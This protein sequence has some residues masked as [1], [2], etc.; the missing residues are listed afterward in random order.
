MIFTAQC[1]LAI[2]IEYK[3]YTKKINK[4]WKDF[5]F[6]V[7]WRQIEPIY[8]SISFSLLFAIHKTSQYRLQNTTKTKTNKLKT[9]IIH[10]KKNN[11]EIFKDLYSMENLRFLRFIFSNLLFTMSKSD[12][13]TNKSNDN[14]TW[15][16]FFFIYAK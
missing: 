3:I 5:G 11:E 6:R 8:Q 12:S 2:Q 15:R 10:K 7:K 13:W 16:I 4:K 1:V 14:C 9:Y